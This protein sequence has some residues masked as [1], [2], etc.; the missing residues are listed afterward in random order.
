[1]GASENVT[2]YCLKCRKNGVKMDNPT[3]ATAKNGKPFWRGICP[4][5]G[6]GM[7]RIIGKT[8]A[9]AS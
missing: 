5:C 4:T 2:G 6:T 9:S 1:M 8:D 7:S 3:M